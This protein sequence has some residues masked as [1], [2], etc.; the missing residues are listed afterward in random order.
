MLY[1]P[2]HAELAQH[3]KTRKLARLLGVSIPTVIGHLHLLWHFALKYAPD[4]DLTPFDDVDLAEAVLWEGDPQALS[5]AFCDAGYVDVGPDDAP[6]RIT[7]HD[8]CQY[9]GKVAAERAANAERMRQARAERRARTPKRRAVHVQGTSGARAVLEESRVEESRAD[10]NPPLTP[11]AGGQPAAPA[12]EQARSRP[13]AAVPKPKDRPPEPDPLRDALVA[14]VGVVPAT[15]AERAAVAKVVRELHDIAGA[16]PPEVLRRCANY[17]ATWP[18]VPL[19]PAA[20]LAHW[21]RMEHAPPPR[22]AASHQVHA[23]PS[24]QISDETLAWLKRKRPEAYE[25]RHE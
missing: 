16:T 22:P 5:A 18:D 25:E 11:P 9:G 15:N 14:G 3:P 21:S 20:L 1:T 6:L 23:P 19:T 12:Q 13:L 24:S 8:W 10:V 17:R 7:I 4:G 2:S